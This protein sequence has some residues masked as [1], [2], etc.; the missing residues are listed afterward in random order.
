M[1][2][3]NVQT[4]VN[5]AGYGKIGPFSSGSYEEEIGMVNV[6]CKALSA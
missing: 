2:R 5:C 1:L 4:L 3:I 6:N